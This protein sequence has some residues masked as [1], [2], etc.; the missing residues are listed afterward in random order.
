MK[1]RFGLLILLAAA[2]Y[3][4]GPVP[5]FGQ[6]YLDY[7]TP[8]IKSLLLEGIEAS[9]QENYPLAESRF[10]TLIRMAPEDPA[11][12][13]F[14]A[15]L[16]H[17]QMI[18]YESNFKE[19]EFYHNVTIAKKLARK[20]INKDKNDP[21]SYLVLGNA[22]GA[23]AVYEAKKGNW[24][25]GLNEGLRAKSALK[26]AIKCDPEL[27]DA[28]VGLG[29]YHY[30]ASV[31]TRA[32]WWLPFVGDH[33]EQGISEM[34]LAYEK[35]IFSRAAAASGLVWIYIEEKQYQEAISL[36][37]Q[38]QSK[39]S[40]GKLFLWPL[41]E[42]YFRKRDW[43]SALVD[44]R[45]LLGRIENEHSSGNPDQSYNLI[46]C[47]FYIANSLF[48]LARYAE[49]DSVCQDILN[50]PF[51]EKIQKR[52]RAKLKSTKTLSERCSEMLGRKD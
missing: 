28:Y 39:Y 17:A 14:L 3:L 49:C 46:E 42:A 48:G 9:F 12:Y 34:K 52:Q 33:R 30:W 5:S 13:F 31:M 4:F 27:Y 43:D 26:Q 44:Y 50:L 2:F 36:A 45:E 18:D 10:Q 24:W 22:Y 6:K 23:K 41:A 29:S 47:K 7:E 38:M 8:Q 25:S 40:Q 15:A 11:G 19:D 20:R 37:Q 35:S 32:L 16:H 1:T 21:W 51:D